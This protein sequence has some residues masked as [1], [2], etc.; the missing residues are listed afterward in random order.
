[1]KTL[2]ELRGNR[3][4]DEMAALVGV[5]P[6]SWKAYETGLRVPRNEVMAR[7]AMLTR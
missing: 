6:A 4:I 1:M 3:S 7:I 5:T 2:K